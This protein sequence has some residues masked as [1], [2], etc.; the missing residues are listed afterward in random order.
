MSLN[1]PW[2]KK[3]QFAGKAPKTPSGRWFNLLSPEE[4]VDSIRRL[5]RSGMA[6]TPIQALTGAR[7]ELIRAIRVGNNSTNC[8]QVAP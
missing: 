5:I 1:H 3:S 8:K 4:Q 2:R 7:E 6:D